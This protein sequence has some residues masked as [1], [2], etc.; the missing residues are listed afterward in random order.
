VA[1]A[2]RIVVLQGPNLN[3]LGNRGPRYGPITLAQVTARMDEE[4]RIAG[5]ALSHHHSNSQGALID[6]VQQEPESQAVI[7]NPGGLT[8]TGIALRDAL[9]DLSLPIA[10]VHVTNAARRELWRQH[11][12]FAEIAD[13]YIAG[14]GPIGYVLAVKGLAEPLGWRAG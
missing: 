2:N 11:D 9:E 12:V 1:V 13:I 4:A 5:F 6:I 8:N 7:I 14:A 10:V 3:R